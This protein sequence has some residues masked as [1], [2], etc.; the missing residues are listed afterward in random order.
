MQSDANGKW[1]KVFPYLVTASVQL[2]CC[3]HETLK[4]SESTSIRSR[5][6]ITTLHNRFAVIQSIQ[7]REVCGFLL[8]REKDQ[9]DPILE[10]GSTIL[11]DNTKRAFSTQWKASLYQEIQHCSEIL[12]NAIANTTHTGTMQVPPSSPTTH[13][14]PQHRTP[15]RSAL[16]HTLQ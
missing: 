14:N 15:P 6:I 2:L 3:A 5:H 9:L 10:K 16:Q 8:C 13:P 1:N 11:G 7:W 4:H 12:N